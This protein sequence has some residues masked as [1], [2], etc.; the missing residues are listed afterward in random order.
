MCNDHTYFHERFGNCDFKRI[1]RADMNRTVNYLTKYMTK[2]DS[3]LIY[4]RGVPD[5]FR[6][7][8]V[9]EGDIFRVVAYENGFVAILCDSVTGIFLPDEDELKEYLD[10]GDIGDFR[11]RLFS[12]MTA[13]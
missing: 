8:E 6:G 10:Y 12:R 1:D 11:S 4:S 5:E 2:T 13:A 9:D 3:K 7:M